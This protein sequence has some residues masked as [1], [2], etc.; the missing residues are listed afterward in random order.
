MPSSDL[1]G[2]AILPAVMGVYRVVAVSMSG[3]TLKLRSAR[4]ATT[5]QELNEGALTCAVL[6]DSRGRDTV[7]TEPFFLG[8]AG[9]FQIGLVVNRSGA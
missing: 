2:V 9:W 5:K 4:S 6:S 1:I 7:P 3:F 8:S